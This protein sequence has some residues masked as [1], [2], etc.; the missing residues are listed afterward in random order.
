MHCPIRTQPRALGVK[1]RPAPAERYVLGIAPLMK[2]KAEDMAERPMTINDLDEDSQK[3]YRIVYIQKH[4]ELIRSTFGILD[5]AMLQYDWV[6]SLLMNIEEVF[7]N[8]ESFSESSVRASRNKISI[9]SCLHYLVD[10][11][12]EMDFGQR[13]IFRINSTDGRVQALKAVIFD[14]VE[15]RMSWADGRRTILA[16]FDAVDVAETYKSLLRTFNTTV[17]PKTL[18]PL[19]GKI[20]KAKDHEAKMASTHAFLCL[21]PFSNRK[22]LENNVCL[23]REIVRRTLAAGAE[24]H[25][26]NMDGMSTVMMPCLFLKSEKDVALED[27]L[28][29]VE[30]TKFLFREFDELIVLRKIE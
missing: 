9:P 5:K 11:L 29:L 15:A 18:I 20:S 22:I 21:L 16:D 23:C 1:N 6:S 25:Q 7:T 10:M 4:S 13:G 12:L 28:M 17:I 8:R 30:F 19:I 27:I 14:V 2:E 24:K 3:K 26:M